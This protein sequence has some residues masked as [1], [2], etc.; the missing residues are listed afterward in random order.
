[1]H[2]ALTKDHEEWLRTQVRA[3][4]YASLKEAV[5]DAIESLRGEDQEL[6]WAKPLVDKG[7]AELD[8]GE[9]IP[10]EKVFAD[11]ES[12]LRGRT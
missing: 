8:R 9:A 2:I 10:A 11:I 1:M 3:G 6:A 12:R 7:L 4:R 5:A